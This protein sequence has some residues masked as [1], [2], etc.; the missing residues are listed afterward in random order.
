MAAVYLKFLGKGV[1]C[2]KFYQHYR[3]SNGTSDID[4]TETVSEKLPVKGVVE[5]F[6]QLGNHHFV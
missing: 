1:S 5:L 6:M 4:D 3:Y 2:T